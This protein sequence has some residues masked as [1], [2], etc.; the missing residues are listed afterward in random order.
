MVNACVPR[1]GLMEEA[2]RLATRISRFDPL[3]LS[4]AKRALD[5]VPAKISDWRQAFEYGLGVNTRVRERGRVQSNALSGFAAG[6][7]RSG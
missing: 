4:E 5:T 2:E 3:A 7:R 6:Q 1:A